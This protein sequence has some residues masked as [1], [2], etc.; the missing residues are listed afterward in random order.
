MSKKQLANAGWPGCSPAT[1]RTQGNLKR[2]HFGVTLRFTRVLLQSRAGALRA[3]VRLAAC[4]MGPWLTTAWCSASALSRA[5]CSAFLAASS[6]LLTADASRLFSCA[7]PASC[8]S[9]SSFS[10]AS[11]ARS[12]SSAATLSCT[13]LTRTAASSALHAP[14]CGSEPPRLRQAQVGSIPRAFEVTG[15]LPICSRISDFRRLGLVVCSARR[16]LLSPVDS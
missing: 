9:A 16:C 6:A 4:V 15:F 7:R 3:L 8:F 11:S 12:A 1:G 13:P 2:G 10:A 5:S 14:R